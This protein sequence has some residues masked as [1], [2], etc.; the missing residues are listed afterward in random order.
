MEAGDGVR[1]KN[2]VKYSTKIPKSAK[3]SYAA[4]EF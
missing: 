3:T 2:V 1:N 4:A